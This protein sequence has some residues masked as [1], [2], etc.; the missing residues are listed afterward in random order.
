MTAKPDMAATNPD[1]HPSERAPSTN[2]GA[3][4]E[5]VR[6]ITIALPDDVLKKLKIVAIV[7][8]TS[9]SE[10]VADAAAGVVKRDL[11]KVLTKISGE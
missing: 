1:E 8:E 3:Q 6:P 2:S 10:L 11:K 7:R 9:V 5:P 4:T